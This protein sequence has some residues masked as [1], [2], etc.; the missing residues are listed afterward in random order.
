MGKKNWKYKIGCIHKLKCST[1]FDP[2]EFIPPGSSV[3]GIFQTRILEWFAISFSRN[4]IFLTQ[5]LNLGLLHCRQILYQLSY[6]GRSIYY[7][8]EST[9]KA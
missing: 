2:M 9:R 8:I 6:Q 4:G 1:L 5:G 7:K 3:H